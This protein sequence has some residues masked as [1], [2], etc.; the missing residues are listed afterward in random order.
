[1]HSTRNGIDR[2]TPNAILMED[3]MMRRLA[4]GQWVRRMRRANRVRNRLFFSSVRIAQ[5]VGRRR[6]VSGHEECIRRSGAWL[7][8]ACPANDWMGPNSSAAS[9]PMP[10]LKTRHY[11]GLKTKHDKITR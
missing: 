2:A 9:I 6:Q 10:E 4:N 1:V 8:T 5:K 11:V 7:A 3:I